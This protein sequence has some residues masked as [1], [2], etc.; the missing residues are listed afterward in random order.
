MNRF[1]LFLVVL[2]VFCA[3]AFSQAI[4]VPKPPGADTMKVVQLL[5]A[6]RLSFEKKDSVSEFQILA[7]NVRL[8]QDQTLFYCDSAVYNRGSRIIEAFGNVH[9]NDR[10]SVHTYSKYLLYY[11]DTKVAILKQNVK[12]T[13]KTTTLLTEDLT[14]DMN[15]RIGE[16]KT[17]GKLLNKESVLT[18]QEGTYYADLKDVYFKRNVQLKDPK[19]FLKSDSLLYNTE[20]ELTTFIAP[21]YIEDSAKR[22][23]QTSD[24]WYDLKNRRAFFGKRPVIKDGGVRIIADNVETNDSTG[25]NTLTGNAVYV[26]SLQGVSV[27]A[28][29]ILA[30]RAEETF[31]AYQKPLMIIKQ[32]NDSIYVAADTLASGK[33]SKLP[34][35][36]SLYR[37]DSTEKK[38]DSTVVIT[39]T[40]STKKS[41][42][43]TDSS[44]KKSDSTDRYF[45]AWHN[46]RIFSDS[47]QAVSDS[48][49]YSAKD[50][51]F[52]LF[53]NPIVWASKSQVTGD[54]IHL[55]TKNK[56][57]E[58]LHVFEHG[59]AINKSGESMYNQ[60]KGN[61]LN[62]YFVDGNIDYM[63]AQGNAE[64]IY[65]VMDDDSAVVGVNKASSDIIDMRFRNKELYRVVFISSVTG[66]MYPIRQATETE[67][68]L[69]NFKWLEE[70]RPKTK[71]ELFFDEVP[72]PAEAPKEQKAITQ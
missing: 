21:T 14:Y 49:F 63:R 44:G 23:I 12:L 30:N 57:A 39:V 33:L 22:T 53:T 66:T 71:Y 9:I 32:E 2:L 41:L 6:D 69:P 70:R 58:R 67:R 55:Y 17:G 4:P 13:D 24:G 60:I 10:D 61:R 38:L 50:S 34:G 5:H 8:Q 16:Y 19:Y 28:N 52:K 48:L 18:S 43:V 31:I 40:D 29:Y 45:R 37:V 42:A 59:L 27:L 64:S 3:N 11:V 35:Y 1:L 62:G 15:Q 47:L 56:K 46:V 36:D 25:V 7:G 68:Y 72:A 54:T 51:I 26:D 65:Y 20:T